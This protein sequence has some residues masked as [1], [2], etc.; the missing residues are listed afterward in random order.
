MNELRNSFVVVASAFIG[1]AV[2]CGLM[3]WGAGFVLPFTNSD[4]YGYCNVIKVPIYGTITTVR[5]DGGATTVSQEEEPTIPTYPAYDAYTYST[6]IE[7]MIRVA[8]QD[9]SVMG[10]LI[11]IDSYGG[12]PVAST[13]IVQAIRKSGKPSVAVVHEAATSGGYYVAAAANQIFANIESMIGSIGVTSSYVDNAEKNRKEGLTFNQL[14][15]VP[16]K[17]YGSQDK[18]LTAAERELL[19]RDIKISHENFVQNIASLRQLPVEQVAALAD[20]ST[21]L[22]E[23]AL[24]AGL[25][26]AIG[27]TDEALSYLDQ[28]IGEPAIVCW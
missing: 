26:D 25:I 3:L 27:G 9:P 11:D 22:G 6:E 18:P 1:A 14:S 21:I 23:A 4:T 8:S 20:G 13:E 17:D 15:S 2:A 12:T 28:A 19:M 24:Q 5:I 10:F 16:F 7:D